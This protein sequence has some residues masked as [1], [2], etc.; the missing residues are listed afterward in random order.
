MV[1]GQPDFRDR[2]VAIRTDAGLHIGTG[3][4]MRCLTLAEALRELGAQSTF[5][6]RDFAGNL[7]DHIRARGFDCAALAD[8]AGIETTPPNT[9]SH[10]SWLGVPWQRDRD[11]TIDVLTALGDIDLLIVD[12]Y[13]L[14]RPWHR[15]MRDKTRGILMID[16]L[17][18]REYDA[19][20]LLDQT[21]GR[22]AADYT[23]LVPATCHLLLGPDYALL[24]PEFAAAREQALARRSRPRPRPHVLVSLGGVDS[25]NVTL[26]AIQGLEMVGPSRIGEVS[27]VLGANA[28]HID[29]IRAAARAAAIPTNV[30]SNTPHMAELMTD[31]DIAIGGAGTSSWERCTLGLPSLVVVLAENQRLIAANLEKSCA[32]STAGEAATITAEDFARQISRL[33]GDMASLMAMSRAASDVCD[34]CGRMRV[35]SMLQM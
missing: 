13:A 33:L 28:P 2:R 31:A 27:V 16:D 24:R 14:K 32:S 26:S 5:V 34:G 18:D 15:A 8:A 7:I 20:W 4:V 21:L 29:A 23:D 35:A 1:A 3:H 12:H 25:Q 10:T 30:L 19:D 9:Q 11:Q 22:S 6:C 17:A